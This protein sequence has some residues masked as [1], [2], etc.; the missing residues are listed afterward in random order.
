MGWLC[1]YIHLNPVR[2]GICSVEAL[3]SYRFSSY[4]HLWDKRK[5]P[6]SLSFESC[7]ESAGGLKDATAGR[8]KYRDYLDWLSQDEPSQKALSFYRMSK[9]WALGSEDFKRSLLED[10]KSLKASLALGVDQAKEMRTAEDAA[11]SQWLAG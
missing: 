8:K 1:H 7:L 10:E 2:A 11:L 6:K 9:G 3:R 4:F 5:R